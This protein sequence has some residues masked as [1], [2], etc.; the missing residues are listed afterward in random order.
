MTARTLIAR[1]AI[2]VLLASSSTRAVAGPV[3]NRNRIAAPSASAD[4]ALVRNRARVLGERL[5]AAGTRYVAVR[6][7]DL[8]GVETP[9]ETLSPTLFAGARVRQVHISIELRHPLTVSGDRN[10]AAIGT[11]FLEAPRAG[12]DITVAANI[13]TNGITVIAAHPGRGSP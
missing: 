1:F 10:G 7:A 12:I 11:L 2:L 13:F 9:A 3:V 6:D 4:S 5:S 8:R